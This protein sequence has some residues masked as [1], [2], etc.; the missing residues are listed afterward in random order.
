VEP[1]TRR[2]RAATAASG[3]SSSSTDRATASR[4][5]SRARGPLPPL[6]L[7]STTH[8]D[9]TLIYND[10]FTQATFAWSQSFPSRLGYYYRA[11][12]VAT[13]VPSPANG[14]FLAA[15]SVSIARSSF[16]A[17]ANYFHIVSVDAT[18]TVGTAQS[19]F[20]VVVNTTPPSISSSSHPNQTAW[21]NNPAVFFS[22]TLPVPD[23][24]LK[25]VH[26]VFDPYANTVPTT[27]DTFL[28]ITQKQLLVSNVANG[29]WVFHV[30]SRDTR[31]AL[32]TQAA[33]Y[34]VRIGTDPGSGTL[35]G[36]VVDGSSQPVSGATVAVNR[37]LFTQTTTSTGNY[38][39]SAVPAGSWEIEATKAGGT[40]ATVKTATITSGAP[41]TV[42]FVVN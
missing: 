13:T 25:G 33:H 17:G 41:T 8:P 2:I 31:D 14:T 35:S 20:E 16:V 29:I 28:P 6:T 30:I 32:T 11:D 24:S 21:V 15:E 9:P 10:A 40:V 22:W 23:A 3:A 34:Q 36:Q 4:A 27:T 42:N 5:P 12:A 7:T 26:Y 39:F 19:S 18:S 37:G 1:P 38:S